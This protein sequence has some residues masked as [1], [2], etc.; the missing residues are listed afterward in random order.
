MLAIIFESRLEKSGHLLR[1][2]TVRKYVEGGRKA[3]ILNLFIHEYAM[4]MDGVM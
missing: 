1:I 4:C 2:K 3:V